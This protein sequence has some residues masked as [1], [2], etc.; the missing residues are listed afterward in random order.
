MTSRVFRSWRKAHSDILALASLA[1][2]V[3]LGTA[4]SNSTPYLEVTVAKDGIRTAGRNFGALET[5]SV[6]SRLRLPREVHGSWRRWLDTVWSSDNTGSHTIR[7]SVDPDVPYSVVYQL[8]DMFYL[9]HHSLLLEVGSRHP[10]ELAYDS[11]FG[12]ESGDWRCL[13][14]EDSALFFFP[15]RHSLDT[16]PR[17]FPD[18]TVHQLD[19]LGAALRNSSNPSVSPRLHLSQVQDLPFGKFVRILAALD[20]ADRPSLV[21][22]SAPGFGLVLE[23]W[24]GK[25]P[26]PA[27]TDLID[28]GVNP[29]QFLPTSGGRDSGVR[30]EGFDRLYFYETSI[31]ELAT[32]R[33]MYGSAGIPAMPLLLSTKVV[34]KPPFGAGESWEERDLRWKDFPIPDVLPGHALVLRQVVYHP[35]TMKDYPT[36]WVLYDNGKRSGIWG[37]SGGIDNGRVLPDYELRQILSDR[38]GSFTMRLE[39]GSYHSSGTSTKGVELQVE[40]DSGGL[41]LRGV[42][43]AFTYLDDREVVR[44]ETRRGRAMEE[45]EIRNPSKSLLRSCHFLSLQDDDWTWDWERLDR[46]ATCLTRDKKATLKRRPLSKPSFIEAGWKDPEPRRRR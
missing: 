19:S 8:A 10:V 14:L 26:G 39:G 3:E 23:Q 6:T 29:H 28:Q 36:W 12:K 22:L 18:S 13:L 37:S 43:S 34:N 31:A 33:G 7:L 35:Y 16:M 32:R 21:A 11:V 17:A 5:D 20:T 25:H 41:V 4:A 40:A 9:Y 30:L 27:W 46:V 2:L 38:E 45:R 24:L 44:T 42:R 15:A 1:L